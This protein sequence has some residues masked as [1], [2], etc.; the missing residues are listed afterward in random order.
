M[1]G[2]YFGF[3]RFDFGGVKMKTDERLEQLEEAAKKHEI[4]EGIEAGIKIRCYGVWS[5][6]ATA[7]AGIS[8]WISSHYEPVKIGFE[9]FWNALWKN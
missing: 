9:A 2:A 7:I 5:I 6:A 4:K 8:S 3:A 1:D